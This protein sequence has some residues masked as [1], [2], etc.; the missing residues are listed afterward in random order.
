MRLL[1]A[2]LLVSAATLA[3]ELALMRAFSL[4][5]WHHFAYM[6]ISIALLGFGASGTFLSL[7]WRRSVPG[8]TSSP[9]RANPERAF[10]VFA[11]LFAL[12]LPACFVAAQ[13]VSFDPSLFLWDARQMLALAAY[14]LAFF[15]PFF[16]AACAV[17]LLLLVHA[18]QAPRVYFFNL[19]GSGLGSL[20][21]VVFLYL[22]PPERTILLIYV[23]AATAALL[24]LPAF[25][26]ASQVLVLV[27][28]IATFYALQ[29]SDALRLRPSQYK[30]LSLNL[31]LPQAAIVAQRFSPLGRVDVV[32]SPAFRHAPG[33]SLAARATPPPQLGLF[34]D[35]DSAGA[36]TAFDG[37][38][39]PLEFLDWTSGAAPYHLLAN[40]SAARVLIL[41]AG[42][43][44]DVLLALSHR[45]ARIEGVELNPQIIALV[46]GTYADFTGGLYD[47][48]PVRLHN[49]EARGFIESLPG[50][51]SFDLIQ[52][53]LLDSLA[54][55]TAGV[56]ALNESYLYT[57]EA[58][59]RYTDHLSDN[60]VLSITRWL[61]MPPRDTLKLFAT[62]VAALESLQGESSGQ[63]RRVARPGEQLALVRSWATA[64]LL[65][66]RTPFTPEEIAAL[67]EFCRERLF[68]LAYYPGIEASEANRFNR[69]AQP[70]YFEAAQEI[71]ASPERR[72]TFFDNYPFNLR[73]ARDDQPYFDHFFRWRALPLLLRTYGRQWLPMLE[74]GYL[75]LVATLAQAAVISFALILLP[76]LI[77]RRRRAT[78]SVSAAGS[79]GASLARLSR[80]NARG[81]QSRG[82][83]RVFGYFFAIGLGYLFIEIVF[84]QKFTFF[85]ANPIYA[86]AVVLT[87]VL[88]FSG[89]GSFAAGRFALRSSPSVGGL[90]LV[91][92]A[93]ALLTVAAALVLP[94]ILPPLVGLPAPAR[95]V[96]SLALMAP[97]AFLMGMPFPLAWQ[98]L[99][100]AWPA[101][102]PW[103]WGVNGC[104]SVLSAILATLLAMS[105]G[106]RLVLFAAATFY[107]L[108]ALTSPKPTTKPDLDK[109]PARRAD[110][111]TA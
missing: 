38:T 96:L 87:G 66:K 71:L 59:A 95:V 56:H 16:L 2:L 25:R 70:Y 75:I 61:K 17:G 98:R 104:A 47:L 27:L 55:A 15:V 105:F 26:R 101:L 80:A 33:L 52:I 78:P 36:L 51:T 65:V 63:A 44:S 100:A 34:L 35:G 110:S 90:P 83:L 67:K 69:L 54:A 91:C 8:E 30:S 82:R 103:A 89:L 58:F 1:Y 28:L 32:R 79:R 21:L 88:V 57:V 18:R 109:N 41:G 37:R 60:G 106:F 97:L 94:F 6:V 46:R 11:T 111:A 12:S 10:A 73:P 74:W 50:E 99:E 40:R 45:S 102:L 42:G 49:K 107:L 5:L 62:A 48:P 24:A 9:H 29:F 43:G 68:D 14:Y 20:L 53:S 39:A 7:W 81:A 4:V 86:I 23:L 108:A 22:V 19:F 76:L 93:I 31:N 64:T 13:R 85:L 3:Y 92:A 72:A 84:I 77:L